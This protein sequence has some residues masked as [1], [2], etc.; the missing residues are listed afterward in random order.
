M[1][2]VEDPIEIEPLKLFVTGGAGTGKSHLIKT[3]DASLNK[4]L[5]YKSQNLDTLKVLKLA[6]TGVAA[7]NIDGHTI[8]SS[9]GIPVNCHALQI[10]KLSNKRRSL[11]RLE[12]LKVIIIDEI[13]MVSNKLLLHM[14]QRLLDI[15]GY[16]NN[17]D[18]PFAGLTI[19]LP[20]TSC[21]TT[22]SFC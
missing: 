20:T 2:S 10:P 18:K 5:N 14:H 8:H 13:S 21:V 22:T 15:F 19:F 1:I 9:L 16:A 3:I 12:K 17:Y 4:T 6:P 11:L 7:S